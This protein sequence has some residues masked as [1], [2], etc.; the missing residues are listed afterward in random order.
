MAQLA[1]A[2]GLGPGGCRFDSCQR[3]KERGIALRKNVGISVLSKARRLAI[4]P[5]TA[6]GLPHFES[7]FR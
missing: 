4:R 1:E 6:H 7:A 5:N 2:P 3:H